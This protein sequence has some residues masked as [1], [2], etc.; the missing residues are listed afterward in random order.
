MRDQD[1]QCRKVIVMQ[2]GQFPKLSS[3][4]VHVWSVSTVTPKNGVGELDRLLAADEMERASRFRFRHLRDSFVMAR[5]FL[6][7]LLGHYLASDPASIRFIYGE[8]GKPALENGSLLRFNL[9]HSGSMAAVA[10]TLDC[11]IGIDMEQMRSFPDIA[12]VVELYFCPEEAAEIMSFPRAE[13]ERAFFRG[14]TRKEAYIK[15]IGDGLSCPLDSFCVT[16]QPDS[17]ARLLHIGGDRAAAEQWTLEDLPLA[18]DYCA[19]LAY[20]DRQRTLSIFAVQHAS[21]LLR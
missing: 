11:E 12:Q 2:P 19:A 8:K 3:T 4:E 14:W 1:A 13:R 6:R 15:A 5:G 20:R 17:P 16:L 21:D 18:A 10:L 7:I 9:A